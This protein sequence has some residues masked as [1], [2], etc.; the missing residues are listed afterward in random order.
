MGKK[1]ADPAV[2]FFH[3]ARGKAIR[4]GNWKLVFNKDHKKRA[5]WELYDLSVDPN[6][7]ND[8]AE[9]NPQKANELAKLWQ[10]RDQNQVDR[11]RL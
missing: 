2:L 9:R 8:L 6:E 3:H 7:L 5:K 1:Q 4:T 11:N 10:K